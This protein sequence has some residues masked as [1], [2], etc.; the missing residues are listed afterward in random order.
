MLHAFIEVLKGPS[1]DPRA[2]HFCLSYLGSVRLS[3]SV[4]NSLSDYQMFSVFL[5]VEGKKR[6]TCHSSSIAGMSNN[7]PIPSLRESVH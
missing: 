2:T 3:Y 5:M 6:T 7:L 4:I 1:Q